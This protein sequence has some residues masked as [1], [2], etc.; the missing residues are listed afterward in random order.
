MRR[1]QCSSLTGRITGE[2]N[3]ALAQVRSIGRSRNGFF[4]R[5]LEHHPPVRYKEDRNR[6][7]THKARCIG[8]TTNRKAE[9]ELYVCCDMPTGT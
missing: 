2:E 4:S 1:V 5:S 8:G 7:N 3:P 9:G 6:R